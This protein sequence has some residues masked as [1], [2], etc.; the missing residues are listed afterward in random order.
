MLRL[1]IKIFGSFLFDG[2]CLLSSSHLLQWKLYFVYWVSLFMAVTDCV[3]V[4]L[5][6][7]E[8]D[9]DPLFKYFRWSY[10]EL[11]LW[12]IWEIGGSVIIVSR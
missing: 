11:F 10:L 2:F 7:G 6:T 9:C 1:G 12:T 5:M 3:G 8:F 4:L